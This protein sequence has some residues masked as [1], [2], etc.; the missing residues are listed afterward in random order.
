MKFLAEVIDCLIAH[1]E[2]E[3]QTTWAKRD[4]AQR[5]RSID[6]LGSGG[7]AGTRREF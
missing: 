6:P 2:I 3:R 5:A 4:P 1:A 7:Y